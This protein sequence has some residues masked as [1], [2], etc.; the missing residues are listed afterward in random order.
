MFTTNW[1]DIFYL[2]PPTALLFTL[3]LPA[4]D[5]TPQITNRWQHTH[6]ILSNIAFLPTAAAAAEIG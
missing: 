1:V 4:A 2:N 5:Q 3:P 6:Q